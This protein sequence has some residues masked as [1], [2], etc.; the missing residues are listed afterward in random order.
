VVKETEYMSSKREATSSSPRTRKGRREGKKEE[1][2]RTLEISKPGYR[3]AVPQSV[4]QCMAA[5]LSTCFHPPFQ[6]SAAQ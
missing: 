4:L 6:L 1:L 5:H 2:F 3:V